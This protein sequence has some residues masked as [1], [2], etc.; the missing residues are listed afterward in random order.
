MAD[1][2]AKTAATELPV[3]QAAASS[4]GF[5]HGGG[6]GRKGVAA[7]VAQQAELEAEKMTAEKADALV[8]ACGPAAAAVVKPAVVAGATMAVDGSEQAAA[9]GPTRAV[10]PL[11]GQLRTRDEFEDRW[12]DEGLKWAL[13]V[14]AALPVG[15]KLENCYGG[16][17]FLWQ[18][19]GISIRRDK[20]VVKARA[21]LVPE[22][23]KRTAF[24]SPSTRRSGRRSCHGALPTVR[25]VLGSVGGAAMAGKDLEPK[26]C[27]LRENT[28]SGLVECEAVF[29]IRSQMAQHFGEALE[30]II[31]FLHRSPPRP[32]GEGE[33]DTADEGWAFVL[34]QDQPSGALQMVKINYPDWSED[35]EDLLKR[36]VAAFESHAGRPLADD[37]DQWRRVAAWVRG[38]KAD[39]TRIRDKPADECKRRNIAAS[40]HSRRI[41]FFGD[42]QH[43]QQCCPKIGDRVRRFDDSKQ[44]GQFVEG[45]DIGNKQNTHEFIWAPR[46][47][48][49]WLSFPAV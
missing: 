5:R 46:G 27:P 25:V 9:D 15:R 24:A 8:A 40:K 42:V 20:L 10:C 22:N 45:Q 28:E 33:H 35:E 4:P 7:A 11:D 43:E 41:W 39:G 32:N 21:Q 49:A 30:V 38:G 18:P 34:Q 12:N 36:V 31:C 14:E 16:N 3:A 29:P 17:F 2:A 23:K 19:L 37:V 44:P 48:S 26:Q 13:A 6:S 1:T 47:S